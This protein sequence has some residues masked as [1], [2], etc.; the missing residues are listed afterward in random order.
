MPGIVNTPEDEAAW[1]DAKRIVR[2]RYAGREES[3]AD[4]F[5]ALVTTVYKD[6]SKGRKSQTEADDHVDGIDWKA[7]LSYLA[8][9][10][11]DRFDVRT[12]A[13]KLEAGAHVVI[14]TKLGRTMGEGTVLEATSKQVTVRSS[15]DSID[16]DRTFSTDL[17]NF[18]VKKVEEDEATLDEAR[19]KKSSARALHDKIMAKYKGGP[20][21]DKREYPKIRGMEGPFKFKKG[22]ILYWDPKEGQY[23]NSKT[24][25]YVPKDKMVEMAEAVG[26][27]ITRDIPDDPETSDSTGPLPVRP[28]P[29]AEG[30]VG[31]EHVLVAVAGD[32]RYA[33]EVWQD[34]LSIGFTRAMDRHRLPDGVAATLGATLVGLGLINQESPGVDVRG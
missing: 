32:R 28:G 31:V 12:E 24:D 27:E 16:Q 20:A 34:I 22:G 14:T 2:E 15:R 4:S 13:T 10:F 33:E 9:V 21:I 1:T 19:R 8:P 5:Y 30:R 18:F 11:E 7:A 26:V 3:D 23:Y 17:Y 25:I 6:I 29:D